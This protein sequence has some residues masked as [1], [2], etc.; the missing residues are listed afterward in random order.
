M[1]EKKCDVC[2]IGG[3]PGGYVAAIRASR[4]GQKTIL[5]EKDQLG[6]TCLNVGC[7][8]TKTLLASLDALEMV[9]NAAEFGVKVD[10]DC[11]PDWK[12]MLERKE[13]V[14][15]Q[16][17]KGIGALL[18][19]SKV[20]VL[21]DTAKFADR[22]TAK[23]AASGD[24][25]KADKFI[26]A[27]GST[28]AMPGFIPKSNRVLDST[29]LLSIKEI[30]KSL[31]VLGGGV[32]GCEFACLF[33]GLGSKVTVVEML[34]EILPG[35][36][37]EVSKL[38][39]REFKKK[40]IDV[41]VGAPLEDIKATAKAVSGKVGK[42]K[43]SADYMLV[44]IG[45]VPV[46]SEINPA[47]AGVKV[48]EKGFIPVTDRCAT[49]VPGIY[50]I[51]D[52]AGRVQLA[53]MASAMGMVAAENC[54]GTR[55][56][57][58]DDLVPGCVFTSPEIGSVGLTQEACGEKGIEVKIGKFPFSGLGKAMA[59]GETAG[60]CKIIADAETDQVLGAHIAGPH[61]TDLIA[62]IATS[63]NLEI[64]AAELGKAIH[65]HPT[66]GEIAMETAHAVHGECVH[67]PPPRK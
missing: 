24:T 16:L 52:V 53:H 50:A 6:G 62:E 30:P 3:G 60:F 37:G 1:S 33:A 44:S 42:D 67:M 11:A 38:M 41:K 9:R 14:V 7:I 5:V 54:A 47:A 13:K 63:M 27:T 2:V 51:G 20:E 36:D 40:G 26:I 56:T 66:L 43:L 4:L 55:S 34:P 57:F 46:S 45:R 22:K 48:D 10:G 31:I 61:A 59:I 21:T 65:A 23:L 15:A 49:N 19:A 58:R 29:D 8:P 18:K 39:R 32:V 25:V 12:A 17:N 35:Q 28:P 64:T